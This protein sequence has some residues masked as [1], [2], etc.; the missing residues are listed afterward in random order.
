V[1]PQHTLCTEDVVVEVP[2]P[3]ANTATPGT[4]ERWS[5]IMASPDQQFDLLS[6]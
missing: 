5:N 1:A 3:V 6:E 4:H 2:G